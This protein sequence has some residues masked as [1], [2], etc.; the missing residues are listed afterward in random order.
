MGDS[1]LDSL[2]LPLSG[3]VPSDQLTETEASAVEQS[4]GAQRRDTTPFITPVIGLI[5][6]EDV[7]V[8]NSASRRTVCSKDATNEY[9]EP[10]ENLKFTVVKQKQKSKEDE[11]KEGEEQLQEEHKTSKRSIR[12]KRKHPDQRH[13]ESDEEEQEVLSMTRTN[14]NKEAKT[15]RKEGWNRAELATCMSK[16]GV[17]TLH[18]PEDPSLCFIYVSCLSSQPRVI[19]ER[20]SVETVSAQQT[21]RRGKFSH[22][23]QQSVR[24]KSP[25][26]TAAHKSTNSQRQKRH[27]DLPGLD[28]KE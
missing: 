18:L 13:S 1:I 17:K 6:N 3:I 7:P 11:G 27:S 5:S 26:K 25:I 22:E 19:I 15:V 8:M 4:D 9:M 2:S 28:D 12:K 20:L 16:L 23:E 24:R 21:G 10:N 14:K